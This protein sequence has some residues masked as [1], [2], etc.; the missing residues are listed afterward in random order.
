MINEKDFLKN[1]TIEKPETKED[2]Q[3][4]KLK[5]QIEALEEK[6]KNQQIKNTQ[7]EQ[8]SKLKSTSE[9]LGGLIKIMLILISPLFILGGF[10]VACASATNRSGRRRR[11]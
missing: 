3:I 7:Q 8:K 5:L 10:L 11:F 6:K 2:L 1:G 4:K 9:A